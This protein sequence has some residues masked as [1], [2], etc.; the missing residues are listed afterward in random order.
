MA[1]T[2]KYMGVTIDDNEILMALLNWLPEK[3]N[4]LINA[5]NAVVCDDYIFNLTLC[6]VGVNKKKKDHCR[7]MFNISQNREQLP[8]SHLSLYRK[9]ICA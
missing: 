4:S 5:L 6:H 8:D 2:L 1:S 9:M 3:F 7:D